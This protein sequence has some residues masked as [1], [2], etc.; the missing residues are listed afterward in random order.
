MHLYQTEKA[1]AERMLK[2]ALEK[3]ATFVD[4]ADVDGNGVSEE[5][6][7]EVL[8]MNDDLR[9]KIFLQSKCGIHRGVMFDFSK[10]WILKAVDGSLKRLKTD[11]LDM[12]LLHRPDTLVEP[13]EVGE[14]FDILIA[15]G[16]V[17]NFGVS[18]QDPYMIELIQNSVR[19]PIAVNQLQFSLTNAT[20]ITQ[21]MNLN[22]Q[23]EPSVSRDN[24]VLNYCRMKNIAIQAWSPFQHGFFG[25]TFLGNPDYAKLNE[26]IGELAEKYSVPDAAIAAAWLI[27]HPAGVQPVT[28]TVNAD[29]L[30]DI[31]KAEKADLTRQEWYALYL[32]AGHRLP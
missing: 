13:D 22:M 16:K 10:E 9:E 11:Y 29:H 8:N 3:G 14:A 7:A 15:K 5:I 20:L 23:D 30:S 21:S 32:A 26:K 27:R 31:L 19:P 17:R 24:G 12:L 6:F 18:N 28:G 2:T 1:N 4:H 25:G